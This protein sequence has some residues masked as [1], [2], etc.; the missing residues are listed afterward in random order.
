MHQDAWHR[1]RGGQVGFSEAMAALLLG[2]LPHCLEQSVLVPPSCLD[3]KAPGLNPASP[4][5]EG[6]GRATG[7]CAYSGAGEVS[8]YL[9]TVDNQIWMKG[10]V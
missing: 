2:T 10:L 9:P 3:P 6:R 8:G 1:V 7:E 4:P 5:G